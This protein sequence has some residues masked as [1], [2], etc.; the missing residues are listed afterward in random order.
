M[1][2]GMIVTCP[3]CG[4][5]YDEGKVSEAGHFMNCD[6]G[7]ERNRHAEEFAKFKTMSIDDRLN[8][9]YER[10]VKTM[11]K[12]SSISRNPQIY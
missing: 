12:V 1:A 3:L 8:Y 2:V 5:S 10:M 7:A 9:L 11:D 6:K 4:K